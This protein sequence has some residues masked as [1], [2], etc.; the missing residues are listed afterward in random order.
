M[1][2]VA[3]ALRRPYTFIV[4]GILIVLLGIFSIV[5]TPKDIFSDIN[6]PVIAV[7]WN[8]SGL[9][10][11]EM[12]KHIISVTER[13]LTTIVNDIEH[14]ESNCYNGI[15]VVKI[16]LQPNANVPIGLAQVAA[17][18]QTAIKQ[19]PPGATPPLILSFSASNVPVL[20]L[21]LSGNTLSE[22]Q[23][24]DLALNFLRVQLITVPG[25]ARTK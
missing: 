17:V 1:W 4:V 25:A 3:L 6:I 21:G 22:Q 5:R 14:I 23:L 12:E 9:P 2:I 16:Y 8:Y 7:I 11:E 15:A 20:R 19:L 10:A 24:N 13:G 18:S